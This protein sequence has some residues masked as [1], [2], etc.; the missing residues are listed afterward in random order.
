[1]E[2]LRADTM[3]VCMGVRRA[4][5]IVEKILEESPGVPVA[6]LGPLI[7]NRRVVEDFRARGVIPVDD[8][9]QVE[10]G[11]LVIRAHGVGPDVR[12]R[13]A[14][15]GLSC[16]DATCPHVLRI[17]RT[18]RRHDALGFHVIIVGD[19]GHG[20]VQGIRGYARDA[21]VIAS[22]EQARVARLPP[23]TV[24]VS[25]TTFSRAAYGRICDALR[26]REPSAECA[27]GAGVIVFDTTCSATE[28]RQESV[29][30][31]AAAVEAILVIGGSESA[32]TR[33]LFEAARATGRPAW[34]IEGASDIPA[35]VSRF[36]RVGISAGASTPDAVVDEVQLALEAM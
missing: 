13:C 28:E 19:E 17:H 34:R 24:V 25:Q 18:V 4:L 32:N 2:V 27:G 9:S 11:I 29:A 7:H 12:G 6:T 5:A 10:S 16:V 20:E 30:R 36:S 15:E 1:M 31:L 21:E 26:S 3:G 33:W 14:R 23:R 35:E 8:P 22:E